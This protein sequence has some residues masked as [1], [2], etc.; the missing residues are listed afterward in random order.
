M[1]RS[2]MP[3][4]LA[5]PLFAGCLGSSAAVPS[6]AQPAAIAEVRSEKP[7]HASSVVVVI[8]ENRDY[9][10]I[11]GDKEAP[12]INKQLVPQAALMTNSHA[13]THPSQP[14]YLGLFSGSTQGI[15]DDSCPHTFSAANVGEELIAAGSTFDGY[16]ESMPYDGFT[17]C[18]SGEYARKHNPWV[19]FTNVPAS[20]NLIYQG[21]VTPS[22]LTVVVPNLCH[23]MH[24]C[25]TQTGDQWLKSNLPPFLAYDKKHNGLLVL[26][27]D[28]ADPDASGK[29]QIATLLIGPMIE[30]GKYAQDITHY[31]T[32]RTIEDIFGV[33]CTADACQAH[34]LKGM[35]R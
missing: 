27:W 28:E 34:D 5:A 15:N 33:A 29:N 21:F 20:S 16:S 11:I 8:M 25:S 19:N 7:P 18:Y 3:A 9:D 32:L 14:N 31:S 24:D 23:D 1:K 10:L 35:W 4:A 6:R 30:P 26:T 13:I 22:A 17:G 12:Y 2:L